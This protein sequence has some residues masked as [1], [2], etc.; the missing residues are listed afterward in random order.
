M[1]ILKRESDPTSKFELFQR[2]NT[3]GASLSEQE[4]RN[5]TLVM[6]NPELQKWIENLS[7]VPSF[8]QSIRITEAAMEKQLTMELVLRF[9]AFR[10]VPYG[11]GLDVHDYLDHASITI[12]RD[13]AFPT[14]AERAVFIA[15]FDAIH[16]ALGS[17]AFRRWEGSKFTGKFLMSVFEVLAF[18]L[19]MNLSKVNKLSPSQRST[20]IQKRAKDLWTQVEFRKYSGPGVRGSDRLS[21]LLPMATEFMK[22]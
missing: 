7:A 3:G 15:T 17:S 8:K 4:V 21:H 11:K 6:I 5:C 12:A 13:Q 10:R 16:G 22:P 2:L 9:L 14:E 1:E 18:G 19:S 20:Y